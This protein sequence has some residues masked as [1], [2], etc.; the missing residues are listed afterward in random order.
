MDPVVREDGASSRRAARVQRHLD[1]FQPESAENRHQRSD[2]RI[3]EDLGKL[4]V[5]Y[6]LAESFS[7]GL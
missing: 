7:G 3:S 6:R 5:L 4:H 1:H 2:D